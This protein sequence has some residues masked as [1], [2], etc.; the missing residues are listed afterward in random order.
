MFSALVV[1]YNR[2]DLLKQSLSALR[3]QTYQDIEI[4]VANNG[5]TDG[6]AHYLAEIVDEDNRLKVVHFDENHWSLADPNMPMAVCTSAALE[7]ATGEYVWYQNDD[8]MVADD[9]LEKMVSLFEGNTECTT[10]SGLPVSIDFDGKVMENGPRVSNYR[11]RYMPG[12]LL[13]LNVS[14]GAGV[15]FN[16]PG[17]LFS[18]KR[19]LLINSGGFHRDIEASHLYGIVPFG[20]TGFD[21]TAQLYWRRH[22][23]QG[24]IVVTGRGWVGFVDYRL[25][26]LKE[27]NLEQRWQ[28]FGIDIARKLTHDLVLQAYA[29]AAAW[30]INHLMSG[31]ILYAGGI[32]LKMWRHRLFWQAL[33]GES[34]HQ[35]VWLA[36]FK[37]LRGLGLRL[38]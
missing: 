20:I 10:A 11:P 38:G 16:S 3:R 2:L 31:K 9:Y 22:E 5:S 1:T 35:R 33:A 23:G 27:W 7:L 30:F 25:Q 13:A 12:H 32:L 4:I 6:T 36:P 26:M 19:E 29:T 15:M 24:N 34:I 28:V 37:A 14:R 21:E 17:P 18:I 8:D